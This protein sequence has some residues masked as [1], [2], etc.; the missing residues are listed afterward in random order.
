MNSIEVI[1]SGSLSTV[2]DAGRF[3]A[4]K[5]GVSVCGAMDLRAL[6]SGN[7]LVGNDANM[8]G[9]ELTIGSPAFKFQ[10]QT[11]IALTGSGMSAKLDGT[12]VPIWESFFAP[13]GS[14]IRFLPSANQEGLRLYLCVEGG[15]ETDSVLGSQS[16][17]IGSGVGGRQLSLGDTISIGPI[18]KQN[19]A[20]NLIPIELRPKLSTKIK[21][22][23]ISGPQEGV[24][25]KRGLNTFYNSE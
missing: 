22:N 11:L 10:Q 5:Y 13:K 9:I 12:P 23:V 2:Q 7:M 25:T 17:H 15:I 6:F 21:I 1:Q 24:F 8:A 20:G 16:T 3:G 19:V 18:S 4:Q 14:V